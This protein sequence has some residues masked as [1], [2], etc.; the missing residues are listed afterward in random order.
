MD[1]RVDTPSPQ[2]VEEDIKEE[3]VDSQTEEMFEMKEEEPLEP[4]TEEV[5]PDQPGQL[6]IQFMG[7]IIIHSSYC[8]CPVNIIVYSCKF[9][10]VIVL[11]CCQH[12]LVYKTTF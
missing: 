11:S 10:V 4:Q 7:I 1:D 6:G 12:H 5:E 8:S 2:P 3:P 9:H